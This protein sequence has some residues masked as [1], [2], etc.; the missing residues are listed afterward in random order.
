MIY[1]CVSKCCHQS[2]IRLSIAR[3]RWQAQTKWTCDGV[4]SDLCTWTVDAGNDRTLDGC[5]CGCHI[6]P[7]LASRSG[8][9][10][11]FGKKSCPRRMARS[12]SKYHT[13]SRHLFFFSEDDQLSDQCWAGPISMACCGFVQAGR[14]CDLRRKTSCLIRIKFS[15]SLLMR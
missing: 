1:F 9:L 3:K 2:A 13:Y 8:S 11:F 4:C 12:S 7:V 14:G 10:S 5:S 15:L 6:L